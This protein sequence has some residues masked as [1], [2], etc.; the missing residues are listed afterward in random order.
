MKLS[1]RCAPLRLTLTILLLS[2]LCTST[3]GAGWR[4]SVPVLR[5]HSSARVSQPLLEDEL[6]SIE[7]PLI[8]M[9]ADWTSRS[10]RSIAGQALFTGN[11]AP[12]GNFHVIK[13]A[14]KQATGGLTIIL[15]GTEQLESFPTSKAAFLAAAEKWE[16]AIS[17][18]I[19]IVI[20]VD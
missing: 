2:T 13:R 16:A 3:F 5:A 20:D 9:T 14:R 7:S 19:T 4:G 6:A 12:T 17:T 8:V 1:S 15:R 10:C 11:S 18:P